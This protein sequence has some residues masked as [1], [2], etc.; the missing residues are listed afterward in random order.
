MSTKYE[1]YLTQKNQKTYLSKR[2]DQ[3]YEDI[4]IIW[5]SQQYLFTREYFS[6]SPLFPPITLIF[7]LYYLCRMIYFGIRQNC[8]KKSGDRQA[9][10]FSKFESVHFI[11]FSF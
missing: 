11:F 8:L 9:K 7:D 6:R 5:Y 3:V 1:R 4:R 2:F 10:V